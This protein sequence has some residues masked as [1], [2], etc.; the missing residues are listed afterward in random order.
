MHTITNPIMPFKKPFSILI[1]SLSLFSF[2]N[3]GSTKESDESIT[4]QEN[5]PF[6]IEQ[7]TSQK[8]I[9]GVKEGGSGTEMRANF[10]NIAQGV[11]FK[12][13]YYRGQVTEIKTVFGKKGAYKASFKDE[14]KDFMMDSNPEIEAQ[15]TPRK[16]FP[17]ELKLF[18]AVISYQYQGSISYAKITDVLEKEAL[19]LPSQ[20]PNGID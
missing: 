4:F 16:V 11:V 19:A 13:L 12:D 20:N 7:V 9:A 10:S 18:E 15:N 1:L 6:L 14:A 3:C 2:S 8:W 5:P 17:F